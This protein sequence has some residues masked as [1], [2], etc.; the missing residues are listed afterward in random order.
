MLKP[1]SGRHELTWEWLATAQC[2]TA[3]MVTNFGE[4]R[5]TCALVNEKGQLR[6]DWVRNW[7]AERGKHSLIDSDHECNEFG[8]R[9][10][11]DG[12]EMS[13][14]SSSTVALNGVKVRAVNG[15]STATYCNVVTPSSM[16]H[17]RDERWTPTMAFRSIVKQVGTT[18]SAQTHL[19]SR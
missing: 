13:H 7:E 11:R 15:L 4:I 8:W 2:L 16:W 5:W 1:E 18:A 9:W 3:V 17:Q 10:A 6:V 14:R 19:R 12:E